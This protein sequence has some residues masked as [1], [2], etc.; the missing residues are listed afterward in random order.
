MESCFPE[1]H[2]EKCERQGGRL[3]REQTPVLRLD[4]HERLP[5]EPLNGRVEAILDLEIVPEVDVDVDEAQVCLRGHMVIQG[6]YLAE[7]L[8][9]SEYE[10]EQETPAEEVRKERTSEPFPFTYRIPLE[11]VLPRQRVDDPR[12]LRVNVSQMD[13]DLSSPNELELLAELVVEGVKSAEDAVARTEPQGN[14]TVEAFDAGIPAQSETPLWTV[15]LVSGHEKAAFGDAPQWSDA[16]PGGAKDEQESAETK[17]GEE[18]EIVVRPQNFPSG[19]ENMTD[20]GVGV[21]A[22]ALGGA[23][24]QGAAAQGAEAPEEL[25]REDTLRAGPAD[26]ERPENE[27]APEDERKEEASSD[28][29][30]VMVS[31]RASDK[32]VT[33]GETPWSEWLVSSQHQKSGNGS[34]PREAVPSAMAEKVSGVEGKASADNSPPAESALP[35]ASDER[36]ERRGAKETPTLSDYLAPILRGKAER[37]VSLRL[38]RVKETEHVEDVAQQFNVSVA[39][40]MRLNRIDQPTFLSA[41]NVLFIPL[42]RE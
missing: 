8:P 32:S 14:R 16:E 26:E 25:L 42:K 20:E 27:T 28:A 2:G 23:A 6:T 18:F 19:Q 17:S 31:A 35:E 11:I 29:V 39:E 24:A 37:F 9:L 15:Q 3:L 5:L 34:A 41:G 1:L 33:D 12:Q 13:F 21:E 38:Y 30:R 22:P 4:L 10:W 40:L 7:P 36:P